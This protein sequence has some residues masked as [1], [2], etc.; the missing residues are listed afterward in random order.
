QSQPAQQATAQTVSTMINLPTMKCDNCAETITNAVQKLDGVQDV[1]V[2]VGTKTA[3]VHYIA[4]KLDQKKI[5]DA[6]ANA[7]YDANSTKRNDE[8][9]N[10]LKE[11]CKQ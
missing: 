11:C 6:I 3:E 10:N 1:K 4:A 8:A 5:E 9:Y 2:D 7:G